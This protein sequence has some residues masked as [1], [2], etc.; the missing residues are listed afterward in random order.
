MS[1]KNTLFL[2]T[3]KGLIVCSRRSGGW[4][5]SE[6]HFDGIPVTFTYEDERN[7][8]WWAA[9][10]HGHWGV[11][12]HRSSDRGASWEEVSAPAYPEG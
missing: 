6:S 11:K 10:D 12:L 4:A 5:I 1:R 8:A 9:L 3:R 7:G 2:S